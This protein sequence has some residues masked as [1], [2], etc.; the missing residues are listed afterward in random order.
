MRIANRKA[1]YLQKINFKFLRMT[2]KIFNLLIM[3]N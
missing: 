1:L 3:S 2:Y